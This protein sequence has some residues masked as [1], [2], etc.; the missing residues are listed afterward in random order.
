MID[1]LIASWL[2]RRIGNLYPVVGAAIVLLA[3][4]ATYLWKK[5]WLSPIWKNRLARLVRFWNRG[6]SPPALPAPDA[7]SRPADNGVEKKTNSNPYDTG[8]MF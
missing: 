8:G 6:S 1:G 4:L 2:E 7:D 5:G 3:I